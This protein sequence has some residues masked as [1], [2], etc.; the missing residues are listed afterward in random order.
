M[1]TWNFPSIVEEWKGV[2]ER[3][4]YVLVVIVV[5]GFLLLLP[6]DREQTEELIAQT[7]EIFQLEAFEQHLSAH[8][9]LIHGAGTTK[10]V[11]TLKNDGQTIYAQDRV[12]ESQGRNT[13]ETVIIGSGSSQQVVEVQQNYPEF[14][15]ALVICEGGDNATVQLQMVQAVAALTGLRSDHITVCRSIN[16]LK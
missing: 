1:K 10:V 11:L 14:Q 2:L 13:T 6:S 8:L 15:G 12:I 3:Y 9:S 16:N 5:G 7:S 4:K